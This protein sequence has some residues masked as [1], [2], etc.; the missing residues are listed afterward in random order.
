MVKVKVVARG[1][2]AFGG[3]GNLSFVNWLPLM[4]R[5]IADGF[6]RRKS[7]SDNPERSARRQEDM[8]EAKI[9]DF[10]AGLAV[11]VR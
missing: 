6:I 10:L 11:A 7:A 5:T 8:V 1:D 2:G 4:G 9:A 3:H